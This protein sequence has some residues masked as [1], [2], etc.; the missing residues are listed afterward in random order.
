[1]KFLVGMGANP[2]I[3]SRISEKESETVLEV[4]ARWNY[5]ALVSYLLTIN[6]WNK[7]ELGGASASCNSREIKYLIKR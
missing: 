5:V 3:R 6:E 2:Q 7:K 1:M 4:A